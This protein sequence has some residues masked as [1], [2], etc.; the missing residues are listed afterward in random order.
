MD[1]PFASLE[2]AIDYALAYGLENIRIAGA[3]ELNRP[4]NVYRNMRIDGGWRREESGTSP[5]LIL[6]DG[7][8]WDIG[9]GTG[10]VLSGLR[11]ERISGDSPI[12]QAERNGKLEITGST[13]VHAGPILLMNEGVC[14]IRDSQVFTKISGEQR[15]AALSL[16]ESAMQISGSRIQHEGD[17]G[18]LFDI[19]G[20]SLSAE[21]SAFLSAGGRTTTVF[22]LN[23]IRGNLSNLTLSAAAQ[24]YAS[25]LEASGSALVLSGGTLGASARDANTIL[26][27]RSAAVFLDALIRVEGSFTARAA[28]IRGQFPVIRNCRFYAISNVN[29]GAAGRSEVFSGIEVTTPN[30]GSITDNLFVGF[31]HIWGGDWPVEMLASFNRAFA[32]PQSPNF[33]QGVPAG[34]LLRLPSHGP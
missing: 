17:Y 6:G 34:P 7:F 25:V 1:N 20:G 21:D 29:H 18:L 16:R 24:D 23:G 8:F 33:V 26:L 9:S 5:A 28:E 11:A 30:A 27:D 10:L 4:V 13:F 12:I 32:S 31:T 2:E 14:E 22:A 3:L 15:I 19:S